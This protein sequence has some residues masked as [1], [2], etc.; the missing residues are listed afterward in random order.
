[1]V[2]DTNSGYD[3][4]LGKD[5]RNLHTMHALGLNWRH[6]GAAPTNQVQRDRF[7]RRIRNQALGLPDGHALRGYLFQNEWREG[8]HW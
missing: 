1:M 6:S 2:G 5:D 7:A 4:G 8:A 3:S